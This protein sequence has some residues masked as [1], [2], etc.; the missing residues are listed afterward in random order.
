MSDKSG[1]SSWAYDENNRPTSESRTQNGVTRTASYGYFANGNLTSFGSNSLS[2]DQANKWTS[3]TVNGSSVS[4]GYDGHGRRTFRTVA[5]SR[6][7]HW[8]DWSGLTL[9][10]GG[11]SATFLRDPDG[12]LLSMRSGGVT[13]NYG[14]D[15][16]GSI[17]ALATT[18]QTL[19]RTHL[20]DPWGQSIG[21]SGSTYNP[22][23]YTATYNDGN[24]LYLMGQ[25]YYQLASGR[26][27]QLDPLPESI[28]EVN[29]Y[30]YAGCNPTNFVDPTG[31]RQC[32]PQETFESGLT[33]AGSG[34]TGAAALAGALAATGGL[35]AVGF[36]AAGVLYFS[37]GYY[38]AKTFDCLRG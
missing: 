35:A 26:F 17:T 21:G 36:L 24:G 19:A 11:S 23:Q 4:F 33:T 20:Y 31:L 29:R 38:G 18:G 9:E 15:R 10:T 22:F 7:D 16:L 13:H 32:S 37:T 27:T 30:P 14:R 6:T 5:G 12:L 28:L 1:S 3:G 2:Y 34:I 8:Y 25:R